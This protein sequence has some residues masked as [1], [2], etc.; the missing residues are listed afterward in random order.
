MAIPGIMAAVA[1]IFLL[2]PKIGFINS[3]IRT[4]SGTEMAAGPLNIYT[5]PG[6]IFVEGIRMVPT[7]FLM[8]SGPFRSMDPTL[9]EASRTSGKSIMVTLRRVTFP[10]MWPAIAGA[11]FYYLIV[12]MEVFEIPGVLGLTAGV[13]VFSTRI[14]YAAN[15]SYG[16]PDYGL[17]SV[18]G[19]LLVIIYEEIL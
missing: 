4:L 13:H 16:I 7:I 2:D 12:V 9:E 5:L 15:P 18:L 1:W 3:I 19:L 11:V 10:L 6:M 8:I 14:Y 17:A